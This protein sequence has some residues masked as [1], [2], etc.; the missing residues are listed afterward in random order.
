[1]YEKLI[2]TVI[3]TTMAVPC[4]KCNTEHEVDSLGYFVF[5]GDVTI[6]LHG[7]IIGATEKDGEKIRA[8]AYCTGCAIEILQDA[9]TTRDTNGR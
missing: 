2:E 4:K 5:Y 1:M 7:G 8:L 9:I 6:G 3:K